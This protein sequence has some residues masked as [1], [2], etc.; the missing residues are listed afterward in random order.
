M[1][2]IINLV[3]SIVLIPKL[4]IL[5][6]LVGTSCSYLYRTLDVLIYSRK[7]IPDYSQL[8]TFKLLFINMLLFIVVYFINTLL[9]SYLK[10]SCW[11]NW[12]IAGFLNICV[13]LI[14]FLV[15]NLFL[16]KYLKDIFK[17]KRGLK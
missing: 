7:L 16:N 5:G 17:E 6:A 15:L 8:F 11:F 14:I 9:N 10:I 12:I 3:V 1:E 4:G 13:G 2:A